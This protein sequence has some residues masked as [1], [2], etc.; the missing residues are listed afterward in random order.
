MAQRVITAF[1]NHCLG[2]APYGKMRQFD[3]GGTHAGDWGWYFVST[4]KVSPRGLLRR[5]FLALTLPATAAAVLTGCHAGGDNEAPAVQA[6]PLPAALEPSQLPVSI[7]EV[8]E[9]RLPF[10][11]E[12]AIV[13]NPAPDDDA[14]KVTGVR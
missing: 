8:R 5:E 6:A 4:P 2:I 7:A 13:F 10:G 11:A 14:S 3:P 12:P 1:C 9:F